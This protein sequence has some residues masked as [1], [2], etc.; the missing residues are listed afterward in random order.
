MLS[1]LRE[2]PGSNPGQALFASVICLCVG[3]FFL[4]LGALIYMR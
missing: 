2:A 3:P 4:Q 1:N